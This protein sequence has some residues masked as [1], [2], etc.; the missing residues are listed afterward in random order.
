MRNGP[1]AA[2][3]SPRSTPI[4]AAGT[5]SWLEEAAA[6]HRAGVGDVLA[7][8]A[9]P[10]AVAFASARVCDHVDE[11]PQVLVGVW[12][13]AAV[14]LVLFGRGAGDFGGDGLDRAVIGR[15]VAVCVSRYLQ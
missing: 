1:R 15:P 4:R 8:A 14:A 11:A 9:E 2:A 13:S 10:A 6:G 12:G 5:P 3:H 7:E